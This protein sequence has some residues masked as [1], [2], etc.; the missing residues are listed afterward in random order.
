[1]NDEKLKNFHLKIF[2]FIDNEEL[3]RIIDDLIL[4]FSLEEFYIHNNYLSVHKNEE[5]SLVI[6]LE[7]DLLTLKYVNGSN[8]QEIIVNSETISVIK[9]IYKNKYIQCDEYVY[10]RRGKQTLQD[11]WI[12]N[13]VQ[14]PS[15][16]EIIRLYVDDENYNYINYKSYKKNNISFYKN[17]Y[18]EISLSNLIS[19]NNEQIS[20]HYSEITRDEF[21]Q[22]LK[23]LKMNSKI[24]VKSKKEKGY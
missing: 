10:D 6:V 12:S 20:T 24:F 9:N 15:K 23:K 7:E 4:R 11:T 16:L 14:G 22:Q 17:V 21:M 19:G 3:Q 8:S 1:M 5:E 2:S 18:N 13:L